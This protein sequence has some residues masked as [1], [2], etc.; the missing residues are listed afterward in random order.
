M[1]ALIALTRCDRCAIIQADYD[2]SLVLASY[3]FSSSFGQRELDVANPII[4]YTQRTG[5]GLA[6]GNSYISSISAHIPLSNSL[7]SLI[8]VP[9][10]VEGAIRGVIVVEASRYD[11]FTE[12]DLDICREIARELSLSFRYAQVSDRLVDSHQIANPGSRP[13]RYP[14][15]PVPIPA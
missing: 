2:I 4:S 1:Q 7:P 13:G 8:S 6:T 5:K 12:K 10:T 3:G 11:A 14:F 15:N 9:I